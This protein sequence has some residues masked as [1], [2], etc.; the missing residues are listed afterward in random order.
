MQTEFVGYFA[1]LP[2]G[3]GEIGVTH[4]ASA[5]DHEADCAT[6]MSLAA[7]GDSEYRLWVSDH[8]DSN[9]FTSRQGDRLAVRQGKDAVDRAQ[10]VFLRVARSISR[11]LWCTCYVYLVGQVADDRVECNCVIQARI[12][13]L[14]FKLELRALHAPCTIL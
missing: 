1:V 4:G 10:R 6:D 11:C 7:E 3:F 14:H 13:D 5:G 8:G 9:G 2:A 12:D